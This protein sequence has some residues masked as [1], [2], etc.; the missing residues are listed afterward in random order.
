MTRL[1]PVGRLVG[2]VAVG[3][4][5]TLAY[6]TSAWILTALLPNAAW[7]ASTVAYALASTLSYLGHRTITFASQVT[8]RRTGP[9]FAGLA[10]T[11]YGT[12]IVV[13]LIL[14]DANDAH[15]LLAI[16]VTCVLVPALNIWALTSWVFRAPMSGS[17]HRFGDAA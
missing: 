12:A 6:G 13:P 16:G 10:V 11:G 8:H 2:L 4:A 9:R 17:R 14:T 1:P 3:L 5:A 15:P 7:L